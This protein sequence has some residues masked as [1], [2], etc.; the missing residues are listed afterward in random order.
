MPKNVRSGFITLS[1]FIKTYGINRSL[2]ARSIGMP[3]GT[4]KNKLSSTLPQYR[5]SPLEYS[6]LIV[7]LRKM[8]VDFDRLPFEL[9]D[10]D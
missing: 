2:L 3:V 8:V 1:S 6:M 9:Y 4:F 5:F 10:G 7:E